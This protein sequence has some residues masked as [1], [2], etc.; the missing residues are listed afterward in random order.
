M[1][2]FIESSFEG[3]NKYNGFFFSKETGTN[4]NQFDK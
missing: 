4:K 2:H 1:S 3:D